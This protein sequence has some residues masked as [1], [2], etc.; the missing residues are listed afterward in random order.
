[1]ARVV[2][3]ALAL[4]LLALLA[5][6]ATAYARPGAMA[7]ELGGKVE[8]SQ[9]REFGYAEIT[10]GESGLFGGFSDADSGKPML[11][12]WMSHGDR[13]EVV[14][15]G[16]AISASSPNSLIASSADIAD[17]YLATIAPDDQP[18]AV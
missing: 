14:P 8:A 11:K 4:A 5:P 10:P 13:V 16:F 15:P 1:M 9:H 18:A 7:A 12:V 3:A 17:V 2:D 6:L